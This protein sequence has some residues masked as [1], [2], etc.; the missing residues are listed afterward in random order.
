MLIIGA[1]VF[2]VALIGIAWRIH[3]IGIVSIVPDAL[4]VRWAPLSR[5]PQDPIGEAMR[6]ELGD[7]YC[8]GGIKDEDRLIV[9]ERWWEDGGAE[10]LI[11][12]RNQW[13]AGAPLRIR[14]HPPVWFSAGYSRKLEIVPEFD[15]AE[16]TEIWIPSIPA[17]PIDP[18]MQWYDETI[19]V[20]LVPEGTR[21]LSFHVTLV[22][23]RWHVDDEEPPREVFVWQGHTAM[24]IRITRGV[25][26]VI[27]PVRSDELDDLMRN[28]LRLG[29]HHR[30]CF[31]G[32][33]CE[34]EGEELPTG[35]QLDDLT[36]G[37]VLEFRHEERLV[38][39]GRFW[40][41]CD[42]EWGTPWYAPVEIEGDGEAVFEA[43]R[44]EDGWT[45]VVT[46]DGPTA[47]RDFDSTHYWAGRY[48][49]P[50]SDVE[51]WDKER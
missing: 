22:E 50:L 29:I 25:D 48:A 10:A 8:E 7:R 23:E 2:V 31:P 18:A 41:R 35:P 42:A 14:A 34:T 38:A 46:G 19:E 20:G 1:A 33:W 24:P 43:A 49:I 13:P 37:L 11:E 17:S 9:I 36:I 40:W 44:H 39:W 51:R 4:L 32:V 47:L 5:S 21:E 30:E 12:T 26:D 28:S 3:D 6:L 15:G 16:P 27:T 45:V